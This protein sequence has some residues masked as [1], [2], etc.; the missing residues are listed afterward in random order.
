MVLGPSTH[1]VVPLVRSAKVGPRVRCS[2]PFRRLV[3]ARAASLL[4]LLS[5]VLEGLEHL[6]EAWAGAGCAGSGSADGSG[7]GG[8]GGARAALGVA[9]VLVLE[10]ALGLLALELALGLGAV[11]GLHALVVADQCLAHRGTLGSRGGA[12]R[13]ALSRLAH[14]LALR[15]VR[16]L[17]LVLR[18]AD[19]AHG[20]LAVN[21][22][23]GA[24]S[25]QHNNE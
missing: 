18:A 6:Q 20:A 3:A 12:S 14:R 2:R 9:Q 21:H 24:G 15:A 7:G 22:A 4:T 17:A 19:G 5:L 11:G 1:V 10:G 8:S 13:V 25:L 16:H 23:L